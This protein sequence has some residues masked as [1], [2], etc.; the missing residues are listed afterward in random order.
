MARGVNKVILVGNLTRDLDIRYTP[1]GA[2]VASF[3]IAT[4]EQWK[5]KNSGER[6]ERT[7][8]HNIVVFGK[9]AEICGNYLVKGSQIYCEGSLFTEKWTDKNGTDRYSTK[10]KMK[11]MQM[12]G[13]KSK[14]DQ[15]Q[16]QQQQ[17]RPAQ[18]Q[19]SIPDI[20][21]NAAPVASGADDNAFDD[22]IPF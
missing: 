8:F 19:G 22:D 16:G 18:S 21:D 12:L 9:L 20:G 10:I 4:S 11:D 13:D 3:G 6:Q 2:C 1:S 7:E 15:S 17:Q 5:D 14:S